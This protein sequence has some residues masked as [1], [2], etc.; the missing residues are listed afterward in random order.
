M[1]VWDCH[2]F[3]TSQITSQ[4]TPTYLLVSGAGTSSRRS[5]DVWHAMCPFCRFFPPFFFC[6]SF[7]TFSAKL[8]RPFTSSLSYCMF[9]KV[10]SHIKDDV[11]PKRCISGQSNNVYVRTCTCTYM[12]IILLVTY[13]YIIVLG[14][15]AASPNGLTR[16]KDGESNRIRASQQKV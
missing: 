11:D 16:L 1:W 2:L 5:R 3:S 9:H 6:P 4:E 14:S 8:A 15:V 12:Y 7:Q 10:G 13:L